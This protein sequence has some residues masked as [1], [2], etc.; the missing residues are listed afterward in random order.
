MKFGNDIWQWLKFAIAL[1]KLIKEIFGDDEDK[2]DVKE[3]GSKL[4]I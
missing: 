1:I 4:Q 2:A 3:N